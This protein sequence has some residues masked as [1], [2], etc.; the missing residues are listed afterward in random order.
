MLTRDARAPSYENDHA[1]RKVSWR[2]LKHSLFLA[3]P[4]EW[5]SKVPREQS[6][7]GH[8]YVVQNSV[9][10]AKYL[11]S[12]EGMD[13]HMVHRPVFDSPSLARFGCL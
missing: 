8:A 2:I 7:C 13:V 10:V 6:L 9:A 3:L 5:P 11:E 4:G 12:A 1:F